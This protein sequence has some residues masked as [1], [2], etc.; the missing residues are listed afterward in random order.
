M[1]KRD[2]ALK[3]IIDR[4]DQIRR[5]L[6]LGHCVCCERYIND[7]GQCAA[8]PDPESTSGEVAALICTECYLIVGSVLRSNKFDNPQFWFV[9]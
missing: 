2:R 5:E 3:N 4:A 8:I 9:Y 7:D 1:T 6:E